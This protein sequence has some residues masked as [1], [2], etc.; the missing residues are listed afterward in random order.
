M[1]I[2][3]K[4]HV[5]FWSDP[6][7]TELTP[8]QK[9][10]YIYL[11]T[12]D[13]TKQ[14]G[15]YEI[16][17][18]QI[19]HDTGYN[20]DTVSLLLMLFTKAGK[21]VCSDTTNEIAIKNWNKYNDSSSP[22]V[23]K[24]VNKELEK[25]KDKSLVQCV[26]SVVALPQEEEEQEEEREQEDWLDKIKF[27]DPYPF[28]SFWNDY[29]KKRGRANCERKYAKLSLKDKLAIKEHV[30][31]YVASTPDPQYRKDPETY[32][33]G[34]H[35]NDEIITKPTEVVADKKTNVLPG[36]LIYNKK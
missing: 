33:N 28:E 5:S 32:L 16:T 8:E 20:V 23:Q 19:C 18:K 6:F 27:K 14:C 29:N 13:K 34:K 31:R 12:N 25:V 24:C 1:A 2:F 21:I 26:H 4:L 35:W 9:Y 11:L 3:R 17:K 7:V 10:F 30:L 22:S 15:I 36:V